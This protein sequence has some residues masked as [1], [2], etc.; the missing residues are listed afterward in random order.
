MSEHN[1]SQTD[2]RDGRWSKEEHQKFLVGIIYIDSG[3]EIYGR[4]WKEISKLV[5][6]R[7]GSQIRS[8]AQKYF[9]KLKKTNPEKEE[10]SDPMP[11]SQEQLSVPETET[12]SNCSYYFHEMYFCLNVSSK[13]TMETPEFKFWD[14]LIAV[15][16]EN[17]SAASKICQ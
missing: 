1:E 14:Q 13:Y 8:H 17:S 9:D 15:E 5:A 10:T 11:I 4:N 16:Y 6:T 7:T 2:A 12:N 3:L